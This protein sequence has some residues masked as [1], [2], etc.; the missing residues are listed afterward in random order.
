MNKSSLLSAAAFGLL[1]ASQT[2]SA[3]E[4]KKTE[5]AAKPEAKAEAVQAKLDETKAPMGEC[6]GINTCK[7]KSMCAV[8]GANGCHAQNS[9]K[10]KGWLSMN[11][12]DCKAK[13]GKWAA[14]K[15]AMPTTK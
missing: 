1:L 3:N 15:E 5:P 13:K 6:H 11:E 4:A 2:V 10:G 14:T 12:K 9:C 7:G 8:E